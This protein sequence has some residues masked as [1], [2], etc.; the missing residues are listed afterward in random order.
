MSKSGESYRHKDKAVSRPEAGAQRKIQK[1]ISRK[2]PQQYQFDSSLDPELRWDSSEI[3]K[4]AEQLVRVVQESDS[5]D[6]TK[7][8]VAEISRQLKQPHLDWSGKAEN[9]SIEIE[10][11]PLFVHERLC[12]P[13]LLANLKHKKRNK[14]QMLD[15][16]GEVDRTCEEKLLGAYE[17][18]DGWQNRMI[19]GDSLLV[20]NSLLRYESMGGKV[21]MVYIPPLWDK[22]WR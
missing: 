9:S 21:Q 17:H 8:S 1:S 18:Q 20:M 12:T 11:L 6:A 10:T 4:I 16:F 15:L 22:V 2:K 19:F 7:E 13:E 14:E 5:L 3:Q